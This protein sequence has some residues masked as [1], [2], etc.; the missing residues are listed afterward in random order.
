MVSTTEAFLYKKYY[1]KPVIE[2]FIKVFI[3]SVVK[4]VMMFML[5]HV[6]V[7]GK[8]RTCFKKIMYDFF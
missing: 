6:R 1:N 8:S 7:F 2:C 4:R 3:I 5:K